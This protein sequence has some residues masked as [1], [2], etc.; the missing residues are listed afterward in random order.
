MARLL[1]SRDSTAV[2]LGADKVANAIK[3]Q[4]DSKSLNDFNVQAFTVGLLFYGIGNFI[5]T[6]RNRG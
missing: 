2:S 5:S 1:I 4:A 3:Q 6:Q